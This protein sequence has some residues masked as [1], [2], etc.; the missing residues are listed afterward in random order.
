M[1]RRRLLGLGALLLLTTGCSAFSDASGERRAGRGGVLPAGVRRRAGGRRPRRRHGLTTPGK[2]PHDLELTIKETADIARADLVIYEADFQAAVDDAVEQN[3][4]GDVPRRGR[5]RRAPAL[6][7]GRPRG[8]RQSDEDHSDHDHESGLD[9][10]F[11]LD[12]L[13]MADPRRRRGLL[14]HRDR[15]RACRRLRQQRRSPARRPRGPRP[16]LHR[17]VWP[18]AS[19]RPSSCR[20]TPSATSE[21]TASRSLRW[22]VSPPRR[23]PLRRPR[24]PAAA[25]RRR[26]HHHRLQRA[27][28]Q[29]AAHADARRRHGRG[30][31]RPRPD[32]GAVRRDLRRGLPQ[33]HGREP[34]RSRGGERMHAESA[35][36]TP[37]CSST[38]P[39]PS[40]A[41]RCCAAST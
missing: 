33:P 5:G 37:S 4:A 6:R 38:A 25:D 8:R 29:P 31:R 27:A 7:R 17:P 11:W 32:R 2:E 24:R 41:A 22:R 39:S 13:R 15:P 21:A 36:R 19:D 12:P 26:R 40:V 9:P 1:R 20:T 34:D 23:S 35:Q 10:H 16:S 28:R 30:H 3:A 18:T 14:A